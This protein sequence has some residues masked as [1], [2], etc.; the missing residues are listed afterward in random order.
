MGVH[1]TLV[2]SCVQFE[3]SAI[4]LSLI[5]WLLSLVLPLIVV[6]ENGG[7]VTG[8]VV[9]TKNLF[10]GCAC[11]SHLDCVA[12][13]TAFQDLG[14]F[15]GLDLLMKSTA[16]SVIVVPTAIGTLC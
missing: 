13:H 6:V 2:G 11:I 9:L 5:P 1:C 4:R 12:Q 7:K 15:S 16:I 3:G 14:R 8:F 10:S